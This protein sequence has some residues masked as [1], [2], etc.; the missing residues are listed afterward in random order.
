MDFNISRKQPFKYIK[1]TYWLYGVWKIREMLV[2][3]FHGDLPVSRF[4]GKSEDI[5]TNTTVVQSLE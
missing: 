2:L 4:Y 1:V 3:H 5:V